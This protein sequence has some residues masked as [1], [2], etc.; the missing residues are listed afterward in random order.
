MGKK[1]KIASTQNL[2]KDFLGGLRNVILTSDE[3]DGDIYLVQGIM[4]KGSAVPVHIHELEDE[5]FHVL[6]GSVELVLGEETIEGK[7]GD[8][9]YLPRGIKHGIKTLG[10]ETAKVLNYVIPGKNF[11]AFFDKMNHIGLDASKEEK[12]KIAVEYGIRFL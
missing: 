11:E 4:P 2:E 7:K 10:D 1:P 8:I 5:I 6:E 12:A 9:I 3:T